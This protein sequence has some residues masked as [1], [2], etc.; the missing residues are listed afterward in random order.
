MNDAAAMG[1]LHR[2]CNFQ[3]GH[4]RKSF[5]Q[6]FVVADVARERI[7]FDQR[8]GDVVCAID[9]AHIENRT[10]VRVCQIRSR[11]CLAVKAIDQS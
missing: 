8:H 4:R 6:F 7:A 5:G 3:N 11:S 1:L 2:S 9:F 10:Q